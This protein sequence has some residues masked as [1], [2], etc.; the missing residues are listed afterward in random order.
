MKV[1][2]LIKWLLDKDMDAEVFIVGCKKTNGYYEQEVYFYTKFD[3][4]NNFIYDE[5]NIESKQLY[6]GLDSPY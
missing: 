6:L 2:E 3:G 5:R 1:K 4:E